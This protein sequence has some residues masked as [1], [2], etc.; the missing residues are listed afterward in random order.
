LL[1]K[2]SLVKAFKVP[3]PQTSFLFAA[4]HFV[5]AYPVDFA[6]VILITPPKG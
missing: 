4:A 2:E 5:P 3:E 1:S 6:L